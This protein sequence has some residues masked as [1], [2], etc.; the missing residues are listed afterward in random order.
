M[1]KK[2]PAGKE[3]GISSSCH[4]HGFYT[5]TVQTRHTLYPIPGGPFL[6]SFS[7]THTRTH[8]RTAS[9]HTVPQRLPLPLR[10]HNA[11]TPKPSFLI[12][13][14][15][16]ITHLH[17]SLPICLLTCGFQTEN[18]HAFLIVLKPVTCSAHLNVFQ[19]TKFVIRLKSMPKQADSRSR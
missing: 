3:S 7:Q 17:L 15:T 4:A 10:G 6:A 12:H 14:L 18:F 16:L 9:T 5:E 11:R 2:Y 13:V 8:A 1:L 19:Q